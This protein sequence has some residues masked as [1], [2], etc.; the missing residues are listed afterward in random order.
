MANSG[1]DDTSSSE[2]SPTSNDVT[3]HVASRTVIS[4]T[5]ARNSLSSSKYSRKTLKLSSTISSGLY[6]RT[7]SSS[8]RSAPAAPSLRSA[9]PMS[10]NRTTRSI[11]SGRKKSKPCEKRSI[12]RGGSESVVTYSTE[13]AR[14]ALANSACSDSTV[15]PEP[16]RPVTNTEDPL[17]IPPRST[18]S[19]PGV[20]VVM[21]AGRSSCRA[22]RGIYR[23]SSSQLLYDGQPL[24]EPSRQLFAENPR[25]DQKQHAIQRRECIADFFVRSLGERSP[26]TVE[27]NVIVDAAKRS[28]A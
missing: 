4:A 21:R 24:G 20:P 18:S 7:I 8:W 25:Y 6:V 16:G 1:S 5:N 10:Q 12:L 17:G 14:R 26:D 27:L 15:F 11:S 2:Y 13:S 3:S 19:R 9:P 22:S 23:T 28:H